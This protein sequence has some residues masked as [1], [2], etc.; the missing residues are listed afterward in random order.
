M[1]CISTVPSGVVEIYAIPI[2]KGVIKKWISWN[3]LR[4]WT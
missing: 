3:L 2:S 1:A 4:R